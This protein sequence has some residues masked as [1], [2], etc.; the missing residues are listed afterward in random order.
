[1]KRLTKRKLRTV[2]SIYDLENDMVIR[3]HVKPRKGLFTPHGVAGLTIDVGDFTGERESVINYENGE[4]ELVKDNYHVGKVPHM[5]MKGFWTGETRF[6]LQKKMKEGDKAKRPATIEE[7]DVMIATYEQDVLSA[8]GSSQSPK[9]AKPSFSKP[10]FEVHESQVGS[11]FAALDEHAVPDTAC[12]KTLI[13]DYTLR[14][15]ECK[16]GLRGLKVVRRPEKNYF[17]F[18][19]AGT[20]TS[21]EI[22]Q[23]PVSLGSRRVVIHAAVLP[24][25]GSHTPF[26]LSKEILKQLHCV[27]NMQDDL[28]CFQKLGH[29]KI[30]MKRTERGHYAIPVLEPSESPGGC[31]KQFETRSNA[32]KSSGEG[33]DQRAPSS[34]GEPGGDLRWDPD[35]PSAR[36]VR[37][38]RRL[39]HFWRRDDPGR[40][41]QGQEDDERSIHRRQDLHQLG[42]GAHQ[43]DFSE[44][45]DSSS[46]VCGVSRREQDG[47]HAGDERDEK[48]L[49][50]PDAKDTNAGSQD[51]DGSKEEP[52]SRRRWMG[53]AG[54]PVQH[55]HGGM[56]TGTRGDSG[57]HDTPRDERGSGQL[58]EDGSHAPSRTCPKLQLGENN[59]RGHVQTEEIEIVEKGLDE[60]VR[61]VKDSKERL[62]VLIIN[63]N[64]ESVD[65]AEVF[66]LPRMCKAAQ[67][68]GLKCGGSY[69]I[70]NGWD[71]RVEGKRKELR[72]HLRTLRPRLLIVCPPCGPFSQLQE[73]NKMRNL[74]GY[75]QKLSEG[76][77]LLR[78]AMELCKDQMDR[79][80]CFCSSTLKEPSHGVTRRFKSCCMILVCIR[81]RW[82]SACMG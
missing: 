44:G 9:G 59:E 31:R 64:D 8:V 6:S 37:R 76:K 57:D 42:E 14:G 72:E 2:G 15:L 39:S 50:E 45:D 26:L 30:R 46:S 77:M 65:V 27:M 80:I 35:R 19:N 22:A 34:G 21:H 12:R 33:V 55:G 82:T 47:A 13:G 10:H 68:A 40:E 73:L 54:E 32:K 56:G 75:L 58:R 70:L 11:V 1:M 28:C 43:Q 20:L 36:H 4:G 3:K 23:I 78:F 53:R 69:D 29:E 38:R 62:D 66:S 81:K 7:Y 74:K 17:K 16:L 63:P 60:L 79:G 41:V 51:K 67:Q 48:E 71:L 18:G 61:R 5:K 52:H 25:D 49:H 24:G